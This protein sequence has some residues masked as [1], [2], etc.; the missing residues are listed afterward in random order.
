MALIPIETR[1]RTEMADYFEE[2]A[3]LRQWMRV[4][5]ALAR[6]HAK[7]GHIPKEAPAQIEAGMGKVKLA[8]VQAIEAET[9]HDLMAMVKALT[10]QSGAAGA[11]V[12]L[13]ATSYDIED[14]ATALTLR[15]AARLARKRVVELRAVLK[16]LALDNAKRVC[17]GRTHGQHAVPTTYGM[18]FALHY[19]A[20]GRH[21]ARLD[22]AIERVSFGKMSG[23]TGTMA[24]FGADAFKLEE[25]VMKDLGLQADPVSTQIVMRDRHAEVLFALALIATSIEQ[26]AQEIRN[27]QRSEIGEVAESF[28][29]KQVGSSTM[30]Q[31]RNPHKSERLCSLARVV[32]AQIPIALENIPSEHER[33]LTNSAAER[34]VFPTVFCTTDFMLLELAKILSNLTFDEAAIERN[35][36]LSRGGILAERVMMALSA[37]GMG[38]QDAHEL[39]RTAAHK[40]AGMGKPLLDVLRESAEVKRLLKDKELAALFDPSTYVGQAPQIVKRAVDDEA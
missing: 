3:K 40:A 17:V 13:G 31:K 21:L 24:T 23:A 32:R 11:Y 28:G 14:T 4:E 6:A 9:H 34:Y 20:F 27:L 38:R 36:A 18:K 25:L 10:E 39:V 15:D 35:L 7:L 16:K 22:A 1:Y 30:P 33:D 2:E 26:V 37:K 29:A 12:H 19:A 8:R 5:V